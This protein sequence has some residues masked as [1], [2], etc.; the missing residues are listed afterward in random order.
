MATVEARAKAIRSLQGY[1]PRLTAARLDVAPFAALY[2]L[3]LFGTLW[4]YL[5]Q[6]EYALPPSNQSRAGVNGGLAP[7]VPS[8]VS[9]A[10]NCVSSLPS[11]CHLLGGGDHDLSRP[12]GSVY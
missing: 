11:L 10:R 12:V 7:R 2:A 5:Q 8:I 9:Y 3:L 4:Q 6:A 1:V